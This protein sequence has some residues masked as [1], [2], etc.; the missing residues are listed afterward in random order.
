MFMTD[1]CIYMPIHTCIQI[2]IQNLLLT[3]LI[4]CVIVNYLLKYLLNG[5][6]IN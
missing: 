1:A 2:K 5:K 4:K 3:N 6:F